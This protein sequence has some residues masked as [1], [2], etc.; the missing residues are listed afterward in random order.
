MQR[1]AL[2]AVGAL[3]LAGCS[4]GSEATP[5]MPTDSPS[6]P[7][8]LTEYY[9]QELSWQACGEDFECA[10]LRV[11]RD[12][13]DPGSGE[14]FDLALLR[15]PSRGGAELGSLVLNPGGPGG[16]GV[17]YA[18]A[19]RAVVSPAIQDAYDI[20]GFDP[21]GVADSDPVECLSD[22]ELDALIDADP[23][24]DDDAEVR[25]LIDDAGGLGQGCAAR[26]PEIYR[27]MDT[28]S[29]ARDMDILRA[30]LGDP[31]LNYLGKSYGT[32]LG[33]AY[34]EQFPDNV[35]RM[36]LDGVLAPDLTAEEVSLGQ[37][38]AFEEALERFVADCLD[39][40]DCPLVADDVD[41]G[42][43][44]IRAFLA[45]LDTRPLPAQP[46][47]PLTEAL[48]SAAILYYLYFPPGDWAQLRSGLSA[49]FAGDGAPL[50][51]LLDA[52]LDRDPSTGRYRDNAQEAFYAVT[53]LDRSFGDVAE[54]PGRAERFAEQAP[55]VGPYLAWSD[56][57]C[58]QWPIPPVNEPREISAEGSAPILVVS[59]QYDTATPYEWG[60]RLDDMLADSALVSYNGQT[61]TAYRQGSSCVDDAVD[62]YLLTG[63]LPDKDPRCGY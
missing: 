23:T 40:N 36:V 14:V 31:R 30:A 52:R 3:L 48:G 25:A 54:V 35:G 24:P 17:G 43:A 16:S 1:I 62:D 51:G 44:E 58:A 11:P 6:V 49:A 61:H 5:P 27:W 33:A 32:A 22:A 38:V 26:S 12:Y 45:G 13:A 18:R 39:R 46:D 55:T 60:V 20:V 57:V 7:A 8:D 50:L 42:V 47:R 10:T 29:A 9:D 28:V 21:R 41:A 4:G 56:A 2:A 37:A 19:A 63:E 34:A 15:A 53:C 59:T